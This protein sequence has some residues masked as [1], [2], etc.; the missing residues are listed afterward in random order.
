MAEDKKLRSLLLKSNFPCCWENHLSL[1]P[2]NLMEHGRNLVV[3]LPAVP[4]SSHH[5]ADYFTQGHANSPGKVV[6]PLC[7]V[8]CVLW[9]KGNRCVHR[10]EGDDCNT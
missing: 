6:L 8:C 10:N 5:A 1:H 7:A 2:E 9:C 3:H 4:R